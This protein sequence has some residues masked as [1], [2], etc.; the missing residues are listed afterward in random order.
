MCTCVR[1]NACVNTCVTAR[2]VIHWLRQTK[3]DSQPRILSLAAQHMQ[4]TVTEIHT[5]T[6][7]HTPHWTRIHAPSTLTHKLCNTEAGVYPP[8]RGQDPRGCLLGSLGPALRDV[9][10]QFRER[11]GGEVRATGNWSNRSITQKSLYFADPEEGFNSSSPG[12]WVS[13]DVLHKTQTVTHIHGNPV[14]EGKLCLST[15]QAVRNSF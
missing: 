15:S 7:T 8:S 14:S 13:V 11:W 10:N 3:Y 4:H 1:V 9:I 5:D 2:K 6:H 12:V